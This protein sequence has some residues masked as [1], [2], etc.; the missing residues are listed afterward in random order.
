M[1]SKSLSERYSDA[2]ARIHARRR[3]KL[4]DILTQENSGNIDDINDVNS[5]PGLA[6]TTKSK[7]IKIVAFQ[8]ISN[9][10]EEMAERQSNNNTISRYGAKRNVTDNKKN[11]EKAPLQFPANDSLES[12]KDTELANII[13][14]HQ[15]LLSL[16]TS[17]A[18][19]LVN[20]C[21]LHEDTENSNEIVNNLLSGTA[22]RASVYCTPDLKTLVWEKIEMPGVNSIPISE[23]AAI[24]CIYAKDLNSTFLP[25]EAPIL[26]VMVRGENNAYDFVC[27]DLDVR[28]SWAQGLSLAYGL[29]TCPVPGNK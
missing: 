13:R 26:R 10:S 2:V 6:E 11:I 15:H 3:L 24:A 9:N 22:V 21:P 17:G 20:I 14:T 7:N 16:I 28:L 23:I 25:N 12:D 18:E 27:S 8:S 5:K 19:M 4:N 29:Q 1:M